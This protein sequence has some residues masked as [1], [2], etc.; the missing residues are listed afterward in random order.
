MTYEELGK[1]AK[2]KYPQYQKIPD[3]ELG[4]KLAEKYPQYK[5]KITNQALIGENVQ[6]T[7]QKKPGILKRIGSA[8]I[9]SEK[10]LADN[11]V[12]AFGPKQY[13]MEQAVQATQSS[14]KLIEIARK[15]PVGDPRRKQLLNQAAQTAGISTGQAQEQL[16]SLP[17]N[18]QVIGNSI[19]V[20]ADVASA[21]TYKSVGTGAKSFTLLGKAKPAQVV[22]KTPL[23]AFARGFIRGGKQAAPVGVAY[24]VSGALQENKSGKEVV[25]SGIKGGIFNAILGGLFEGRATQKR[26]SAPEKAAKLREKSIQQY[27]IGLGAT[28]DK[29]KETADKIIP[30]LLDSKT[31]GTRRSLIK[32][33][34]E[35][36]ALSSAEY[37]KLGELS[38]VASTNGLLQKIDDQL[39]SLRVGDRV[40]SVNTSKYKALQELRDDII[41]LQV[42][43]SVGNPVVYQQQLRELAQTYGDV[44]YEG[45]K[46]IKTIEDSQKLA[47][48]RQVD[49]AIR[50]LLN[51]KN[52]TYEKINKV[53][54]A[55]S[56]LADV[57]AETSKRESSGLGIGRLSKEVVGGLGAVAGGSVAGLPGT[58]VSAAVA[59]AFVAMLRSTWWNTMSAVRKNNLA[60]KL[61]K[62][63]EKQ[64]NQFLLML[65]N[66]GAKFAKQSGLLD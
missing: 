47:P 55:S 52:P 10:G 35:G 12:S 28:K 49:S 59:S 42:M 7:P 44:L 40:I 32:K 21:G 37:K 65:G 53:Y 36:L 6:S 62:L 29:Y 66:Q 26:F 39:K 4:Q 14:G 27:K 13:T 41:S 16:S 58:I 1:L 61:L 9:S 51:T 64:R 24:G 22:A 56:R 23:G 19:G 2:Q 45:R 60:I 17:T 34:E 63:P 46:S 57:L 31:W 48:V 15:L 50:D 43:D 18:K 3:A 5:S 54:T 20:L 8:L 33:A 25:E 11:T 30:D 38:G